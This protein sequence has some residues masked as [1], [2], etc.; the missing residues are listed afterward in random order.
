MSNRLY[1]LGTVALA[2]LAGVAGA[3]VRHIGGLVR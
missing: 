3:M 2:I 1:W